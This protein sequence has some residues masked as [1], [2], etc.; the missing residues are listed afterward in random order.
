MMVRLTA[1]D[2]WYP[3]V[4]RCWMAYKKAALRKKNGLLYSFTL[5][6]ATWY[7]NWRFGD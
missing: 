1:M 7:A 4:D 2:L 3:D 6:H 5:G